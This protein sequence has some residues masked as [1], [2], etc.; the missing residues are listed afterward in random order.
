MKPLTIQQ[1]IDNAA[2]GLGSHLIARLKEI[3]AAKTPAEAQA[4]TAKLADQ[5]KCR[6][7]EDGAGNWTF[8]C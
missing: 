3:N 2:P 1:M 5:F 8:V 6:W 7:I 4:M